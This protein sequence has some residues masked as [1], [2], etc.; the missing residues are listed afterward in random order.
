MA[1]KTLKIYNL[2]D[3]LIALTADKESIKLL[4][5]MVNNLR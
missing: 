3:V 2:E 1:I 5:E 4:A